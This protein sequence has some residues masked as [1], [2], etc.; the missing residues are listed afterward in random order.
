MISY[1]LRILQKPFLHFSWKKYLEEAIVFSVVFIVYVLTVSSSISYW[2]SPEFVTTGHL[3]LNSHPPGAPLF[4]IVSSSLSTFYFFADNPFDVV[5]FASVFFACLICVLCYKTCCLIIKQFKKSYSSNLSEF[6]IKLISIASAITLGVSDS[7]WSIAGEAEVYTLSFFI[8]ILLVYITLK[9]YLT[10][11]NEAS[12]FL[13]TALVL[14]LSVGVH[15][16]T[17]LLIIPI[18][19]L[20]F[21]KFYPHAIY[22]HIKGMFL[23]ILTFGFV[24]KIITFGFIELL[25]LFEIQAVNVLHIPQNT[26][27]VIAYVVVL[28]SLLQLSNYFRQK[29][30][31][32]SQLTCLV[33]FFYYLGFS[34]SFTPII[35]SQRGG[36]FKQD[37]E[38]IVDF[39]RYIQATQ[40]GLQKIP[41]LYGYNIDAQVD[42][43]NPSVFTK[44]FYKWSKE[45]NQYELSPIIQT[46]KTNFNTNSLTFFPRMHDQRTIAKLNYPK[47]INSEL[48]Q[49]SK[50]KFTQNLSFFYNYQIKWLYLR[51]L[52]WNFSGRQNFKHG[53]GNILNGNWKTGISFVDTSVLGLDDR[54]KQGTS[55]YM[56]PFAFLIVGFFILRKRIDLFIYLISIAFIFGVGLI[57]I[58]NPSP[59]SILVRERDYIFIGS[60]I[61]GFIIMGLGLAYFINLLTQKFISKKT[62]IPQ[63]IL[64]FFIPIL[65]AFKGWDYH[66][67]SNDNFMLQMGK[68]YL[69]SCPK[70]SVLITNGDNMTFPLHYLQYSENY[71]TDVQV[72]NYDQLNLEWYAKEISKGNKLLENQADHFFNNNLELPKVPE[73]LEFIE[74]QLFFDFLAEKSTGIDYKTHKIKYFPG[75]RFILNL[76]EDEIEFNNNLYPPDIHNAQP[77]SNLKWSY[78]KNSYEVKDLMALALIKEN[79]GHRHIAFLDNGVND[80]FLGLNEYLVQQGLVQVLSPIKRMR[81]GSNPKIVYT[82]KSQQLDVSNYFGNQYSNI[83]FFNSHY[84]SYVQKI[85]RRN[86]YMTAQ[87]LNE[88]NKRVEAIQLLDNMMKSFPNHIVPFK[89][90]AFAIGKL[91]YKLGARNKGFQIIESAIENI[92]FQIDFLSNTNSGNS[93]INE[94]E[95]NDSRYILN[96]MYEQYEEINKEMPKSFKKKVLEYRK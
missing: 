10:R 71:R 1:R 41:L 37:T 72:I 14:G 78:S 52:M 49:D 88:E 82:A 54:Q 87:A 17:L 47:W 53:K 95:L 16:T 59:V 5:N 62:I 2:D 90:Y 32:I 43:I 60:F 75:D 20:I 92:V 3:L 21:V 42:S 96:Q 93:K 27:V 65:F 84:T 91:Y 83:N 55:F 69:D 89:Q 23:G 51:Y 35:H 36:I 80:H 12:Y 33:L 94:H 18:S 58:I 85:L 56:F 44:P 9:M 38:T 73:T 29:S 31:I 79:L 39:K 28:L 24:Y 57:L 40:F 77:L 7:F 30:R 66:N 67:R 13:I 61:I 50:I 48:E 34:I 70:N 11:F 4:S 19:Y 8:F 76:S 68:L 6:K 22:K 81:L 26:I 25:V 63:L 74:L 46:A 15:M 86:T 45:I 64:I